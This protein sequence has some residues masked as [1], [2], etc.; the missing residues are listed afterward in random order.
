[1]QLFSIVLSLEQA[2]I[3]STHGGEKFRYN[4]QQ[5]KQTLRETP[6]FLNSFYYYYYYYTKVFPGLIITTIQTIV[7]DDDKKI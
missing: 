6:F 2:D 5:W 7:Y 3:G 1:M 4:E